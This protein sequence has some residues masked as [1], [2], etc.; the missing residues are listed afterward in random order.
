MMILLGRPNGGVNY[1]A[2][3]GDFDLFYVRD[4]QSK[5][6]EKAKEPEN[7]L[8]YIA[9]CTVLTTNQKKQNCAKLQVFHNFLFLMYYLY[10]VDHCFCFFCVIYCV[11]YL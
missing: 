4:L 7:I 10:L 11:A 3:D 1:F 2:Q 8:T 5:S 6:G 9:G